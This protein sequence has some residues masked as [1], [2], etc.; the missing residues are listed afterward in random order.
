MI[1]VSPTQR[2]CIGVAPGVSAIFSKP[3]SYCKTG[4]R[5][6][7]CTGW[8][9]VLLTVFRHAQL[10]AVID[11]FEFHFIHQRLDEF[12]SPSTPAS[13]F[14]IPVAVLLDN[15]CRDHATARNCND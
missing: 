4:R 12:Q 11:A 6:V 3:P 14:A 15:F 8:Q 1:A 2:A 5:P 9:P 10:R 7:C 13:G